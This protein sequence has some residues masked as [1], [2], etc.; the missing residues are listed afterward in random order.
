MRCDCCDLD[1]DPWELHKIDGKRVCIF[2]FEEM[3]AKI[4]GE[5]PIE[6]ANCGGLLEPYEFE[7]K[8]EPEKTLYCP[9]CYCYQE[10]E[11]KTAKAPEAGR[12]KNGPETTYGK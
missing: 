9:A 6:C 8:G 5:E 2:C 3:S 4:A 7:S 12:S 1:V 10:I 11:P